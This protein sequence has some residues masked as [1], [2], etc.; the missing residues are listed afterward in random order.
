HLDPLPVQRAE[1]ARRAFEGN[2]ALRIDVAAGIRQQQG[3]ADPPRYQTPPP[4]DNTDNA[5]PE[6]R[7]AIPCRTLHIFEPQT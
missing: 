6:S 5:L 2:Q 1:V 3:E 7:W 4:P